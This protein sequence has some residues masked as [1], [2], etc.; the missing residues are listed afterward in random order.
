[1]T[2]RDTSN[3]QTPPRPGQDTDAGAKGRRPADGIAAPSAEEIRAALAAL[4]AIPALARAPKSSRLLTYLVETHLRGAAEDL[5]ETAIARAVF[6]Q[7]AAFNPR[8]NPIVR[9]NAS[10]LRSLLRTHYA[11][12]G[13]NA[14]VQIRLAKVGYS[15]EISYAPSHAPDATTRP[16]ATPSE[17]DADGTGLPQ[18]DA[19]P[20][21]RDTRAQQ[22][23]RPV[24]R[25][26][27]TATGADVPMPAGAS[28]PADTE[29]AAPAASLSALLRA[30][31]A[32]PASLGAVLA[33][34]L[35]AVVVSIAYTELAFHTH[36][37][38]TTASGEEALAPLAFGPRS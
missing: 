9:V 18:P 28:S 38:C 1:M 24:E 12:A 32:A 6:E 8:S 14:P 26:E 4:L 37:G 19:G 22:P 25:G 35:A 11:G 23:T 30:R 21:V 16:P 7:D 20:E 27:A 2:E 31:L 5:T 33:L 10:R 29:G 36:P 17:T 34:T 13:K 3:P 15:P